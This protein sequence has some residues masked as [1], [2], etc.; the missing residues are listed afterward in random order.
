LKVEDQDN[1]MT[2]PLPADLRTAAQ[3][4]ADAMP[5]GEALRYHHAGAQVTALRDVLAAL[6]PEGVRP[7]ACFLVV[8][9]G[10]ADTADAR[11]CNTLADVEVALAEL[12]FGSDDVRDPDNAE[13]LAGLMKALNDPREWEG[14]AF[15]YS[16]E[17][18]GIHVFRLSATPPAVAG[19]GVDALRSLRQDATNEALLIR[20]G[21]DYL[22]GWNEALE[23]AAALSRPDGE[24]VAP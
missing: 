14:G 5:A 16:F 21:A 11:T 24:G 20:H 18:S 4:L 3:A 10:V 6:P 13:E 8:A 7:E 17:D 2:R 23:A 9:F 15:G 1:R 12:V 22:E 19:G